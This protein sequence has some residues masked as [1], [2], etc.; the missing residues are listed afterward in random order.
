MLF[1]FKRILEQFVGIKHSTFE[2]LYILYIFL[3]NKSQWIGN[4]Q[5]KSPSEGIKFRSKIFGF[6]FVS[7]ACMYCSMHNTNLIGLKFWQMPCL[8]I[9]DKCPNLWKINSFQWDYNRSRASR[10]NKRS[11][12]TQEKL[13]K[14]RDLKLNATV[15]SLLYW[16]LPERMV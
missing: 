12:F 14:S 3:Y 2:W 9:P 15:R 4:F 16:H 8:R 11:Q 5:F 1:L 7:N 13:T 10:V 6:P